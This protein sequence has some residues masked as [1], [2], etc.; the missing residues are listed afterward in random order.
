MPTTNNYNFLIDRI[1]TSRQGQASVCALDCVK[2]SISRSSQ[3]R[4][5]SHFTD[6]STVSQDGVERGWIARVGVSV[7]LMYLSPFGR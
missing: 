3:I 7:S 1:I 4:T 5:K 6:H 2:C